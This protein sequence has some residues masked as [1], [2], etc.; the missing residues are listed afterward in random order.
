MEVQPASSV[1]ASVPVKPQQPAHPRWRFLLLLATAVIGLIVLLFFVVQRVALPVDV[2]VLTGTNS[3]TSSRAYALLVSGAMKGDSKQ[4][5]EDFIKAYNLL[6]ISYQANPE[7]NLRAEIQK[8]YTY[9]QKNY[10]SLVKKNNL[11]VPCLE[12][13]C[14]YQAFYNQPLAEI[15]AKINTLKVDQAV[16]ESLLDNLQSAAAAVA[17]GDKSAEF[18]ALGVDFSIL[19]SQW[20]TNRDLSVKELADLVSIQLKSLD[21]Q[22]YDLGYKYGTYNLDK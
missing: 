2:S 15:K 21:P 9:L 10:P 3:V 17:A 6:T 5:P 16:R 19:K 13:I 12:Q 18:N 1:V 20:K 4:K 8:L 14:G 7:A 22:R 11:S